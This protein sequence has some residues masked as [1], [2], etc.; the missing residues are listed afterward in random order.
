MVSVVSGYNTTYTLFEFNNNTAPFYEGV[1]VFGNFLSL[2]IPPGCVLNGQYRSDLINPT[3]RHMYDDGEFVNVIMSPNYPYMVKANE[4]INI[5]YKYNVAYGTITLI[6]LADIPKE[7]LFRITNGKNRT[8]IDSSRE[9]VNN[10]TIQ[11][12][13]TYFEIDFIGN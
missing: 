12:N 5:T 1:Y 11:F 8:F 6:I 2:I 13:D 3:I 9:L 4:N 7:C 10:K